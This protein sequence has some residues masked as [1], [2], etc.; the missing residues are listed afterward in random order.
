MVQDL[1]RPRAHRASSHGPDRRLCR[2]HCQSSPSSRACTFFYE[3]TV[4]HI[5]DGL[6]KQKDVP[7]ELGGSGVV[8]RRSES[9]PALLGLSLPE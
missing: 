1:R 6:P 9:A 4:L 8:A 5:H 7:K 2:H 3:E